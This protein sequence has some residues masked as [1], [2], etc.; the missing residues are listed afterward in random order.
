MLRT[1][2]EHVSAM[3]NAHII[4]IF[5]FT[6]IYLFFVL[7]STKENAD[8]VMRFIGLKNLTPLLSSASPQVVFAITS[9]LG[10]MTLHGKL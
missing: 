9:L 2:N 7:L 8:Q 4:I 6:T 1:L 3:Q 5:C 10:N